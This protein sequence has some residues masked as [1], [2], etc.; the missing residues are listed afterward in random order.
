MTP[1]SEE[2]IRRFSLHVLPAGYCK[3]RYYG[4]YAS[5]NRVWL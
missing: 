5:R 3:I 4:I 1:D 2:F